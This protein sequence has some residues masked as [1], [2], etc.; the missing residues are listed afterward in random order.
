MMWARSVSRFFACAAALTLIFAAACESSLQKDEERLGREYAAD[1]EKHAKL[2]QGDP[3]ERVE[4]VGMAL[5]K[6]A[7]ESEVP[8]RYGS[9]EV[10]KFDYQF[11]VVEDKDVNAFS[12]PGGHVYLNTGLLDLISSDDELAGVLAHEIAHAAHHHMSKLLRKQ[13]SVDK[14][15]A[16]VALAGILGNMRGRDLNNLLMGAQMIK[17]GKLSSYT[18]EAEKDA[19]RTAVAYMVKSNYNPEGLLTFM[20]KLEEKHQENPTLPL[21]IYQTHPAPYR[22]VAAIGQA[23]QEEGIKVNLR[24]ITDVACAKS[25]PADDGGERYRVMVS[26]K[27]LFEPATLK[28]GTTSKE[29]AEQIATR[30]NDALDSKITPR[31]IQENGAG[32][33]SLAAK[34]VEIVRVEPEDARDAEAARV[35]LDKAR[36]AL[37][38]AVWA[39]WL[40]NDCAAAREPVP[41]D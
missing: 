2:V 20:R 5:A 36:A 41:E 31:D 10:C 3:A 28:C 25:V 6:V 37:E 9:S 18:Q 13:A 22:R 40:R 21:G 39:D 33:G 29:R 7:C 26:N 12:L 4:R 19:D 15:I 11:K 35:V 16:I 8:A 34:G 14:Y 17:V 38:Y 32:G 24:H 27:V 1:V 23:M 30:I